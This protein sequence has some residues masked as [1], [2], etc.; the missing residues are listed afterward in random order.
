M[1]VPL[2]QIL[3]IRS[4]DVR[5]AY[6]ERESLLYSLS[7]GL[8]ENPLDENELQFVTEGDQRPRF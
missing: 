2:E 6:S 4:N 3:A 5:F 1:A 8:G 7:I